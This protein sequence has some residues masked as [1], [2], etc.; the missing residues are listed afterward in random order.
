MARFSRE[1]GSAPACFPPILTKDGRGQ[2]RAAGAGLSEGSKPRVIRHL[3]KLLREL[4]LLKFAS[5]GSKLRYQR[6][7]STAMRQQLP[8]ER[9]ET[10]R[11]EYK[12]FVMLSSVKKNLIMVICFSCNLGDHS[13]YK[14]AC[15]GSSAEISSDLKRD[16][17]SLKI[18]PARWVDV[19]SK[20]TIGSCHFE[21][22]LLSY[23]GRHGAISTTPSY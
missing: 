21:E 14:R 6:Q 2:N 17:T 10:D 20:R 8:P 23:F 18:R 5:R 9:S 15:L 19:I 13:R 22:L 7:N 11:G 12:P 3:S 16:V 1:N 4:C